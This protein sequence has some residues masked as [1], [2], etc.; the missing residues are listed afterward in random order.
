MRRMPRLAAVLAAAGLTAFLSVGVT[1]SAR[2]DVVPQPPWSEI[3]P[4]LTDN[5]ACLDDPSGSATSGTALQLFHCHG[6]ASNGGPQRWL[7]NAWGAPNVQNIY[8]INSHNLCL[9]GDPNHGLTP[10]ERAELVTCSG[11]VGGPLWGLHSRNA[12]SMASSARLRSVTPSFENATPTDLTSWT[13]L[14]ISS[15][16]RTGRT[17]SMSD[18]GTD[19]P[20]Q[21]HGIPPAPDDEAP[22]P[23]GV[24]DRHGPVR[25]KLM[26]Q[27][28]GLLRRRIRSEDRARH[29]ARHDLGQGEDQHGHEPQGRQHQPE[30]P[31]QESSHAPFP[32][33]VTPAT[34]WS[35]PE[36]RTRWPRLR[37]RACGP[38]GAPG[39]SR[40]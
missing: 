37:G 29:V 28:R 22:E 12:Y 20:V 35:D 38:P 32:W 19:R 1:A 39:S 30:S 17:A 4:P 34:L 31:E 3:F 25:P 36:S 21:D 40:R 10:G 13:A 14:G 27:G 33:P 9:G 26:P 8:H 15:D 7:F 2:A 6:Y 16:S 18:K 5:L 24:P 23:G 11:L